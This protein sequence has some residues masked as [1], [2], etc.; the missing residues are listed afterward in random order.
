M[1]VRHPYAAVQTAPRKA[2]WRQESPAHRAS[3][4]AFGAMLAKTVAGEEGG[5]GGNRGQSGRP[6]ARLRRQQLTK[7]CGPEQ[8]YGV[9]WLASSP[10]E[11]LVWLCG[12][13]ARLPHIRVRQQP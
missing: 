12:A 10:G 8:S 2:W 5:G 4:A 6:A 11:Q 9:S 13:Y 7:N 3:K 1:T